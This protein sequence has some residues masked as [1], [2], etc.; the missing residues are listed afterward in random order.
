MRFDHRNA[1]RSAQ[2]KLDRRLTRV[3]VHSV[4]VNAASLAKEDARVSNRAKLRHAYGIHELPNVKRLPLL[5]L[6]KQALTRGQG[7][8]YHRR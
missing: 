1:L 5:E 7:G 2:V 4:D 6:G 3:V 8:N